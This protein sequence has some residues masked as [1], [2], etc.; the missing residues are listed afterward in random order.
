MMS[1]SRFVL[2]ARLGVRQNR[3]SV[4]LADKLRKRPLS[5]WS[6]GGVKLSRSGHPRHA[7]GEGQRLLAELIG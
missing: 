1:G 3:T 4:G 2:A 6:T 5:N 7:I